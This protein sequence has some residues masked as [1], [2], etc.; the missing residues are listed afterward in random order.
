MTGSLP[1]AA[2]VVEVL[3][4]RAA[5][6]IIGVLTTGSL[7]E[8]ALAVR[9]SS[10]NSSVVTQRVED[11]RRIDAVEVIPEN[12]ELRLSARGRRLLGMLDGLDLWAA[13]IPDAAQRRTR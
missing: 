6:D 5:I 4:R 2:R 10:F 9:L 12:G 3:S 11:L 8:R 1:G 13:Q 7:A